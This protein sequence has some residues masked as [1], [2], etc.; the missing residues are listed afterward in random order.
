MNP[1]GI[2]TN[3]RTVASSIAAKTA[4]TA[5]RWRSTAARLRSYA[6]SARAN[7]RSAAA[8]NAF[9]ACSDDARRNR[10]HSIGVSV[11]ETTPEMRIAVVSVIANSRNSRPSTP[12]RNRIGMNTAV[13]DTVIVRI[14]N[15]ISPDPVRAASSGEAPRSMCRTM[16]SSMTIAS[17]TTKPSERTSAIID[18][19][20]S[21]KP[22][23]F[24]TAKV[25]STENGSASA[26]MSVADQ[27][28]R[29]RKITPITSTTVSAIVHWMSL[30][31]SRMFFE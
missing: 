13:S 4:M 12:R 20:S 22:S 28:W 31:A 8:P 2:T 19:L 5:T 30:K 17:S 6:P 14:V 18:R 29:N 11:T 16:F 9:C 21:V 10:L 3:M 7:R 15:A 26:G 27:L 1:F 25:P 23:S 24:M